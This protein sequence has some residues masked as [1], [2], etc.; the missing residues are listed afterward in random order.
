MSDD[1]YAIGNSRFREEIENALK[2]R[3]TPRG[4]R[5]LTAG[6]RL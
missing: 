4:P 6:V 3:A 5:R 1:S 2:L